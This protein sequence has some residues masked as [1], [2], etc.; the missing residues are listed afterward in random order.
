MSA[1][2]CGQ[3]GLARRAAGDPQFGRGQPA[4]TQLIERPTHLEGAALED[5]ARHVC[6]GV[7][8]LQPRQRPAGRRAGQ[9]RWP[10]QRREE[11]TVAAGR[12]LS[13]RSVKVA[14]KRLHPLRLAG[15][16]DCQVCPSHQSTVAP[17]PPRNWE[18][19]QRCGAAWK[20]R[21]IAGGI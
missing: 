5:G 17:N 20:L 7:R 21:S 4:R 16:D 11:Q 18:T 8:Q 19:V 3:T 15:S 6:A 14:V 13:Q 2:I 12:A 1:R 9:L 10:A